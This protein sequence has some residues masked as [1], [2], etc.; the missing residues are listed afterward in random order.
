VERKP[1]RILFFEIGMAMDDYP[2]T[3]AHSPRLLCWSRNHVLSVEDQEALRAMLPQAGAVGFVRNGALLPR[4]GGHSD[5]P[6]DA[7]QAVP[8]QSPPNLEREVRP[9]GLHTIALEAFF[10][11]LLASCC[12]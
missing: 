4:M 11:F 9:F 12:L 8:F 10:S 5:R 2:P 7:S 3:I 6:M 1:V